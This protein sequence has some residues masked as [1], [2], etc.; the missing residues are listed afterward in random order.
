MQSETSGNEA[1]T[2]LSRV[3]HKILK[4]NLT[5]DSREDLKSILDEMTD[6]APVHPD[7]MEKY[8]GF[9][10]IDNLRRVFLSGKT[11]VCCHYRCKTDGTFRWVS[12]ELVTAPEYRD[13]NQ[14]VYLYMK[15]IRDEYVSDMEE[16]DFLT[17]GL[18]RRGFMRQARLFLNSADPEKN[19]A[20]VLFNIKGFKGINEMFGTS[21]GDEALREVLIISGNHRWSLLCLP[22]LTETVFCALLIRKN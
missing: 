21:G 12:M 19:Y 5:K 10:D 6:A 8:L 2:V 3:Y 22:A 16:T 1:L 11:Y 4:V 13:D 15:D 14:I 18:N 17:G 7:D 9:T 20:I